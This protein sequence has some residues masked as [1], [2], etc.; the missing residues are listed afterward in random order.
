MKTT[1]TMEM[2]KTT[3][4]ATKMELSVGFADITETTEMMKTMGIWGANLGD[5]PEQ[6]KSR[7]V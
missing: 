4:T 7:Y 3:Q 2:T 5:A 1:K 6:F